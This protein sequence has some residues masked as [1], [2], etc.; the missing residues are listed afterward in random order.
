MGLGHVTL[1]K[2]QSCEELKVSGL[3]RFQAFWHVKLSRVSG[4]S[5]LQGFRHVALLKF[6]ACYVCRVSGMS[7]F[8]GFRHGM[9]LRFRADCTRVVRTKHVVQTD[10]VHR[11]CARDKASLK[12]I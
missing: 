9:P 8:Q 7:G 11:G 6:R 5:R 2:F 1:S 3:S 10:A 4:M 12:Q